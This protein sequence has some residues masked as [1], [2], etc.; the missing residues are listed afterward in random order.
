[1]GAHPARAFAVGIVVF[2]WCASS[3]AFPTSRLTYARGNGAEAC[4]DEPV[5]RQA[6]AA[7]LGYDP[8]FAA[9]DKTIVARIQRSREE[10]R[11]TVELVDDRGIVRGVREFKAKSGQCEELVATMAL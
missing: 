3:S 5:V 8:F 7:R 9:A 10:L 1:M 4:P 2:A 11:A 6:V